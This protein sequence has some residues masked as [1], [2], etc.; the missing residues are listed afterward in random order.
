MRLTITGVVLAGML[1]TACGGSSSGSGPEARNLDRFGDDVERENRTPDLDGPGYQETIAFYHF[2]DQQAVLVARFPNDS[3][4]FSMAASVALFDRDASYDAIRR[5]INGESSGISDP[6]AARPQETVEL[7][8]GEDFEPLDSLYDEDLVRSTGALYERYQLQYSVNSVEE[9][10]LFNLGGFS[11]STP[12]YLWVNDYSDIVNSVLPIEESFSADS[13]AE[14]FSPDYKPLRTRYTRF[15]PSLDDELPAFYY[16][17]CCFDEIANTGHPAI[18]EDRLLVT[19]NSL[20]IQDAYFTIGQVQ[21]LYR[22]VE[23]TPKV[24][25]TLH[26]YSQSGLS[27]WGELDL[28]E[29]YR[30]SFC[31]RDASADGQLSIWADNNAGDDIRNKPFSTASRLLQLPAN[32]LIPGERLTV[33]VP[34]EVLVDSQSD[35]EN[36]VSNTAGTEKSFL[37]L[38][39]DQGGSVTISDLVIEYQNENNAEDLD[40]TAD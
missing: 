36:M 28:S 10:G 2:A 29:P 6:R 11:D 1:L 14:F 22:S 18:D 31:V 19:D 27:S 15:G 9:P 40:C 30:V 5:W 25:S 16:P 12:V 26:H 4:D 33:N 32:V 35:S 24:D 38:R 8:S 13:T 20:R 39:V 17:L 7:Q 34:G 37:Q 23:S 3:R 21:P